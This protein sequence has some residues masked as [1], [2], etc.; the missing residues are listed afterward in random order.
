MFSHLQ[1][2]KYSKPNNPQMDKFFLEKICYF[3]ADER[4][5]FSSTEFSF[6]YLLILLDF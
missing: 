6:I 2:W 5:I 3:V 4:I 1:E